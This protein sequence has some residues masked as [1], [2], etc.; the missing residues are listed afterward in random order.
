M[1]TLAELARDYTSLDGPTLSHV[2]RLVAS[3]GMLSDLCFSDLLLFVPVA[4]SNGTRFVV[5]GQIR[6]TTNQTL[7]QQDLV[8]RIIDEVERPFVASAWRGGEIVEGE[9][10]VT[11]P[12]ERA[13]LQCIPVR[14]RSQLL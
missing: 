8:G 5:L 14:S 4:G 7:Y 1:A 13:R 9:V 2:Q 11:S 6:P 3:W 10:L 12:G